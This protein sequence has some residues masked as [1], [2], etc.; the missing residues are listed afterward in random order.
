MKALIEDALRFVNDPFFEEA[1]IN[2][3]VRLSLMLQKAR[4]AVLEK[5][6]DW[7]GHLRRALQDPDNNIV[8]WR[9]TKPFLSWCEGQSTKAQQSLSE[10][11]EEDTNVYTRFDRFCKVLSGAGITQVGAQLCLTSTLLMANTPFQHPPIRTQ[12]FKKAFEKIGADRFAPKSSAAERYSRAIAFLEE[13]L[14][15]SQSTARPLHHLLETQG[16]I[17]CVTGGWAKS[18]GDTRV[19]N[20]MANLDENADAE[21]EAEKDVLATLPETE[22]QAIVAARRGQGK[23]RQELL[24][25]WHGCAVTGCS[26]VG[27]LRASHLKPWRSSDNRERLDKF[28]GLLLTPNLDVALDRYLISFNDE[29]KIMIAS[30]LNAGDLLSLGIDARMCLRRLDSR[31]KPYLA[32]HRRFFEQCA[33]SSSTTQ[34]Q[35]DEADEE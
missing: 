25:Y 4:D 28:N 32:Y 9:I 33:E 26:R 19:A 24:D 14:S 30:G 11:W 22:R 29:G 1:E 27:M 8:N 34:M 3:K 12:V 21:I 16:A 31:H 13:V 7:I 6:G 17:W 5:S 2:Y 15:A 35:Q 23:F 20:F 18:P 10:L